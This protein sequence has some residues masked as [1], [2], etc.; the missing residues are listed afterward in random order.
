MEAEEEEE[1]EAGNVIRINAGGWEAGE[2]G[3]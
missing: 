1:E 3:Q 2:F